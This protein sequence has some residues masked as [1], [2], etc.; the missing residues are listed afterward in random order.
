MLLP[1][2]Q[3]GISDLLLSPRA[4]I[5]ARNG[6]PSPAPNAFPGAMSLTIRPA[7]PADT[8]LVL[9]LIREIAEYERLAHEV[10]ATPERIAAVLFGAK[11]RVFCEIAEWRGEPAGF[12]LW[13]YTFS[14]FRGRH[15]LYLEDLFVRPPFRHH[16][17]GRALLQKLARRCVDEDLARLEWSVLDWN[18]PALQFYRSI[19]ALPMAEWTVQRLTG[20]ALD[21]LGR[22][23]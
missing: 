11:P 4:W 21:A 18:E 23:S 17:I 5:P 19:G 3:R 16:G 14:S 13:F 8:N 9:A 2:G 20:D 10:D 22:G 1:C 6:L 15:G 12:M 7:E